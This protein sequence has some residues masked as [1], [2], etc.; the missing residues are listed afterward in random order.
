MTKNL[1]SADRKG[2]YL[3]TVVPAIE[4]LTNLSLRV[5]TEISVINRYSFGGPVLLR[6]EGSYT[7][8]LGKD[9][10]RQIEVMNVTEVFRTV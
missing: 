6:V 4:T 7:V 10:A 8:A 3:L 1:Y 2:R 5:G 9:I